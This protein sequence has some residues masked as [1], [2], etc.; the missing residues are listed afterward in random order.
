MF[1]IL[2]F[3]IIIIIIIILL[4]IITTEIELK[5]NINLGF[6]IQLLYDLGKYIKIFQKIMI[7]FQLTCLCKNS[8]FQTLTLI[9][10]VEF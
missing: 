5:K 9:N 10:F 4:F 6:N 8:I 3:I 7:L 1:I 2:L